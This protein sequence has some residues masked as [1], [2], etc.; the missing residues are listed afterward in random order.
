MTFNEYQKKAIALAKPWDDRDM[1]LAYYGLGLA[2]EAGEC[3]DAIKKH[4]SGSKPIDTDA[5]KRELGD[6]LWY[7]NALTT[8]FE[9][10]LDDVAKTNIVKLT[11]RH[12]T[13]WSGYGNREGEGK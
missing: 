2:G 11:A 1:Q 7:L 5:I 10:E 6:V 12:G 3:V 13:H 4:L 9:F 8:H